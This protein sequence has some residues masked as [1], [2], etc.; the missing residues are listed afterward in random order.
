MTIPTVTAMPS[1]PSIADQATF[2]AKAEAFA[3]AWGTFGTELNASIAALNALDAVWNALIGTAGFSGTSTTSMTIGSGTQSFTIE[4]NR[5]FVKGGPVQIADT[6]APTTNYMFG[7]ISSY[8]PGTGA[9]V[10][11]VPSDGFA[12][13]GTKTAWTVSIIGPRGPLPSKASAAEI[14]T[15][16]DDAKYVTAKGLSDASAIVTSS[17]TGSTTLDF[18]AGNNFQLTLTGNITFNVPS[19]MA[20]GQQGVIYFIQDATGSRTL[21]LNASIKKPGGTA[22]TLSTAANSIDRLSYAV[23]GTTLEVT[24]LEKAFA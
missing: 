24:A 16:T 1:P 14:R 13:S 4:T 21:T 10:V 12:G 17:N 8:T 2:D 23:R 6:A 22:L 20:N 3:I 19:N 7:I 5:S 9:M 11:V 18:A 15:Q